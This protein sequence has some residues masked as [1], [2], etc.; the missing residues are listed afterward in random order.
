MSNY[1]LSNLVDR[2]YTAEQELLRCQD[3]VAVVVDK[4]AVLDADIEAEIA[5]N[6]DFRND[7]QRKAAKLEAQRDNLYVVQKNCLMEAK[8][9]VTKAEIELNYW[10]NLFSAKKLEARLEILRLEAVA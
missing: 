1:T 9:K 2:I 10:R 8:K 7:Q 3:A 4:L 5:G 6:S